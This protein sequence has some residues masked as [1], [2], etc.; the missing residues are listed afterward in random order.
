MTDD[1]DWSAGSPNLTPLEFHIRG[2]L[3]NEVCAKP[4]NSKEELCQRVLQHIRGLDPLATTYAVV[5]RNV[6]NVNIHNTYYN[7]F[8]IYLEKCF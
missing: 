1:W 4:I 6:C 2:S 8:F 3:K 7:T 5:D